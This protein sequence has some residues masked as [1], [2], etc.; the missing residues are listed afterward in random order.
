ML[1]AFMEA[2]S[3]QSSA[4]SSD[5][6]EL[7]P[8]GD[9]LAYAIYTSGSTGRPK[10]T[11]LNHRGLCNTVL[12][13]A[14]LARVL[15]MGERS[16]ALP[17]GM[18]LEQLRPLLR[19]FESNLRANQRYTARASGQRLLL[20]KAGEVTHQPEDGGWSAMAG[21]GLERHVL[22]GGHHALLRAPLVRQLAEFLREALASGTQDSR[23]RALQP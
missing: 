8:D 5:D 15:E 12:Q 20:L 18:G 6:L 7:T 1:M 21:G 22:P 11:L 9:N 16:G 2:L 17:P 13:S 10:G 4:F 3:A 19:V 14:V 23:R